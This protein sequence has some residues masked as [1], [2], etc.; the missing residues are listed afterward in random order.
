MLRNMA[1]GRE[2]AHGRGDGIPLAWIVPGM[3]G[4]RW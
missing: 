4:A 2:R 1:I 3:L